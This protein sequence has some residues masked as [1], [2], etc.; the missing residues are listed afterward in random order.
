MDDPAL[1]DA[2]HFQAVRAL[3]RINTVSRTA[4]QI[5]AAVP[6]VVR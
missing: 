2:D 5:A 1:G 3:A 4:A 6:L